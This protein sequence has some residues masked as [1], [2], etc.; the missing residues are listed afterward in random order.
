MSEKGQELRST[1]EYLLVYC[2]LIEAARRR[3]TVTYQEVAEIMGLP[4][5]GS[6]M[7]NKTGAM[8]GAISEAEVA[9]GRPMLSAIVV[10]VDGR[11]GQGLYGLARDLRG[12]Q[13][14]AEEAR[15]RFWETEKNAV[16]ETWRK[17]FQKG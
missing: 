5:K 3:G 13:D 16:Y 12:L 1:K 17:R 15:L 9:H 11:P 7:G 8:V 2:K 10:G 14:D 6:D 4:S